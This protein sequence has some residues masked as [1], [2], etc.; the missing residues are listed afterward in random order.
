[1]LVGFLGVVVGG[2]RT[3][4]V[5]FS[6]HAVPWLPLSNP[7]TTSP[8][9]MRDGLICEKSYNRRFS[10]GPMGLGCRETLG[11]PRCVGVLYTTI[12]TAAL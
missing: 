12:P 8:L 10:G 1:M 2:S 11:R 5:S 6:T 3:H 9:L 7:S 4:C